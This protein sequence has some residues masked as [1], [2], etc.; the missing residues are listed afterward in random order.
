M[1]NAAHD[2]PTSLRPIAAESVFARNMAQLLARTP[3]GT[4]A[5]S[6]SKRYL[7]SYG[8]ELRYEGKLVD[9]LRRLEM[10]NVLRLEW[11]GI[12]RVG[13][14]VEHQSAR[15]RARTRTS[16]RNPCARAHTES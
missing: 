7:A 8:T 6:L 16:C 5:A 4:D 10:S 11:R 13:C 15:T 12:V 3:D 2:D 14:Y 9:F 1:K